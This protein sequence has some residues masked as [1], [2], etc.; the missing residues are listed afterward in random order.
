MLRSTAWINQR[1]G[2]TGLRRALLHTAMPGAT[3]WRQ[4][5]EAGRPAGWPCWR[6]N[7]SSNVNAQ[8]EAI[9]AFDFSGEV[10]KLKRQRR[11]I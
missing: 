11:A 7:N 4:A 2:A 1:Q 8:T 5:E 6:G 3:K 10:D 9:N